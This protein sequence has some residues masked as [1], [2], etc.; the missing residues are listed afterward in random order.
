[1]SITRGRRQAQ[2]I[3]TRSASMAVDPAA[4]PEPGSE[5]SEG[6]RPAVELG[7]PIDDHTSSSYPLYVATPDLLERFGVDPGAVDPDTDV[8]TAQAG[9]AFELVNIPE[10]GTRGQLRTLT[11]TGATSRT[12]RTLTATTAVGLPLLAALAGWLLA[13]R[14]PPSIARQPLQ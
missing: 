2:L 12:R 13:G 5:G 10:R 4:H 14:E 6:G 11:A 8:L 7:Q 9:E 3:A 1:M